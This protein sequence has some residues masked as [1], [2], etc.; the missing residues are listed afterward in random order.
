MPEA[1]ERAPDQPGIRIV[2]VFD[3]PREL[4]FRDWVDAE[5]LR[6]WFAPD[7]YTVTHCSVDARPGGAW[8]VE[9][10]SENGERHAE[11][12]QFEAVDPPSSI[13]FT[14]TQSAGPGRT[15][16]KTRVSVTFTERDGKTEMRF[17]QHGF[18]SE[19]MRDGNA[20]G[21]EECFRKLDRRLGAQR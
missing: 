17:E 1:E 20:A 14:L 16:P 6:T 13:V 12:G 7:G 2:R 8:R 5:E 10:E 21:W 4:V 19:T 15:G 18:T 3:A 11:F 9:F